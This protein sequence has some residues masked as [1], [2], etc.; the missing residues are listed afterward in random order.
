MGAGKRVKDAVATIALESFGALEQVPLLHFLSHYPVTPYTYQVS[1]TVGRGPRLEAGKLAR[2]AGHQY[3]A[4]INLCAEMHGG[5][6]PAIAGTGLADVLRTHHIPVTDMKSP[7]VAQVTAILD[8]LSG[9][10]AELTYVH[11]E[12]GKG[13]TGVA[14]ACY[15]MA[16][17]GWSSAHALTE[18]VNFGCFAPGQLAFIREF[19][20]TLLAGPVGRYPLRPPGSVRATQEQLGATVA[21]AAKA[22]QAAIRQ[23]VPRA[24]KAARQADQ[25]MDS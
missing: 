19:G 24:D 5:D 18:A 20:E 11:C 21:S 4:T 14:I 13:R 9:P 10:D 17:M 25:A 15:R 22:E 12:A 16:V 8:L 7:T 3:R 23:L 6:G 1:Q 2:L